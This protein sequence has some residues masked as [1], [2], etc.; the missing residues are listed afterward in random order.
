MIQRL[1]Y[2]GI[3]VQALLG[4][5]HLSRSAS[6]YKTLNNMNGTTAKHAQRCIRILDP[7]II[8]YTFI[9]K[10]ETV[11]AERFVCLLV[12]EDPKEYM[13]AS[14]LFSFQQ[15]DAA[16]KATNKFK[17]VSLDLKD[18]SLRY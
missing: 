4:T 10:G 9:A 15:R 18:T 1:A 3:I 11:H 12:S 17:G 14:V 8:S 5:L 2:P 16:Q 7:K 13:F 6:K